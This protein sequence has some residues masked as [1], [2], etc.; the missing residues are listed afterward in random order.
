MIG[1]SIVIPSYKEEQRIKKTLES[2]IEYLEKNNFDYEILVVI[3][4]DAEGTLKII[5][6]FKNQKIR[7]I[8]NSGQRS[9]KGNA[10]KRGVIEASKDLVLTCDADL[11]TP[12]ESL[13]EFIKCIPEFDLVIG[14]RNGGSS[15]TNP[16]HRTLSG[17]T[18]NLIVR[19]LLLPNFN[20]TQCG[21]KLFKRTAALKIFSKQTITGF[22]YDVEIL[23]IAVRNNYKIKAVPVVFNNSDNSKVNFFLHP[24]SML[25][26][27]GKI[28]SNDLNKKY[29]LSF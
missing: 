12:I 18:F 24:F 23:L 1:L 29:S 7:P 10:V 13:T 17:K 15:D 19:L 6:D 22:A 3:D 25:T 20:D 4:G 5:V 14:D 28:K 11:S 16:L 26:A 21:F 2:I 27:L 9:G 8:L